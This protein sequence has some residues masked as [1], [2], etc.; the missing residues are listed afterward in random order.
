VIRLSASS[1]AF[2]VAVAA[3]L[4]ACDPHRERGLKGRASDGWSRMYALPPGGEVQIVGGSGSID[5]AAAETPTINV[6]AER[7]VHAVTDAAARGLVPHVRIREETTPAGVLLQ[8]QGLGDGFVGGEVE[9][10]FHVTTPPLTRLRLRTLDGDIRVSGMGGAVVASTSD[11][12]IDLAALGGAVDARSTSG[13]VVID[14]AKL[15]DSVT[16]DVAD[17]SV[18]VRLPPD[19]NADLRVQTTHGS[20]RVARLPL[21]SDEA[22]TDRRLR[23]RLNSGGIP[24]ALTT[25]NGDIRIEPRR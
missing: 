13:A 1:A 6:H 16:A 20:V 2:A 3:T 25:V 19:A 17:G 24:V 18:E 12:R 22:L 8:E 15:S 14:M 10:R 7:I 5:V 4:L 11:G 23:G 21:Q 9:V